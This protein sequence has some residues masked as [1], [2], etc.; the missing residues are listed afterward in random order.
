M[1]PSNQNQCYCICHSPTSSRPYC[2]H[3]EIR[4]TRVMPGQNQTTDAELD[5]ILREVT[6]EFAAQYRMRNEAKDPYSV[7]LAERNAEDAISQAKT[8]LR[9]WR[10]TTS[11]PRKKVIEARINELERV[12]VQTKPAEPINTWI[13]YRLEDLKAALTKEKEG[14]DE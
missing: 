12:W 6:G 3:C 7:K 1:T 2:E 4:V 10:N 8:A 11:I 5:E 9:S 13:Y 14:I